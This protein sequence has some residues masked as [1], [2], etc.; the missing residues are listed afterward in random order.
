MSSRR[1]GL[2]SCLVS[3]LKNNTHITANKLFLKSSQLYDA[4]YIRTF[5]SVCDFFDYCMYLNVMHYASYT[6]IGTDFFPYCLYIVYISAYRMFVY[7]IHYGFITEKNKKSFVLYI[8]KEDLNTSCFSFT[9]FRLFSTI[10]S[11][12]STLVCISWME[13]NSNFP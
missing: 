10:F 6:A 5:S 13:A 7:R 4:A 2:F 1:C 8:S 12:S 11:S 3:S 9:H